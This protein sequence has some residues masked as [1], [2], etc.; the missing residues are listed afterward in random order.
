MIEPVKSMNVFRIMSQ[1][2]FWKFST[3]FLSQRL[4][5]MYLM[6]FSSKFICESTDDCRNNVN[7]QWLEWSESI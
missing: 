2:N 3:P 1:A 5:M 4:L 6:V 7:E